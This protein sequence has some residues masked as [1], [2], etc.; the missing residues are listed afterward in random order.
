MKIVQMHVINFEENHVKT[1]V[2][3]AP[4]IT[5]NFIPPNLRRGNA[6]RITT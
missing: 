6:Q 2:T 3:T 5:I 4:L 1:V